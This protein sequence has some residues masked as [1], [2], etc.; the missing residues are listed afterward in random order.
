LNS[1]TMRQ[2]YSYKVPSELLESHE[3]EALVITCMDFRFHQTTSKFVRDK[4]SIESFDLITV[5][6]VCKGVAEKNELGEYISSVIALSGKLHKI[7]TVI[8]VHH[9]TCGAYG[10][11]DSNKEIEVQ[12]EDLKKADAVLGDIFP[13]LSFQLFFAQKGDGE[14]NYISVE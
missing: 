3:C 11:S 10:I 13:D 14:I 5:P 4:L 8:F 7:K 12:T 2:Q 6:G 9:S 1:T